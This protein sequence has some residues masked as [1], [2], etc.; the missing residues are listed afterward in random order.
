M[1]AS[2]ARALALFDEYAELAPPQRAVALKRLKAREPAL[3][4]ARF[5]PAY[6]TVQVGTIQGGT[7]LN[8]V[9]A[10]CRF[11]FEVRAL[12]DFAPQV[13]AEQLQAYAAREVEPAM[14]AVNAHSAIR[15]EALSSYPG[16]ATPPDSAAAQLTRRFAALGGAATLRAAGEQVYAIGVIAAQ[17]SGEQ[18]VVA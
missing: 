11:D 14:Q 13:V 4:D 9:P 6:S 3:H 16:L 1:S 17:G 8:I 5:D 15:F 2:A 18:V 7:A 12:P 10:D